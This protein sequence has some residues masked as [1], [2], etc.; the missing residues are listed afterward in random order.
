MVWLKS[1]GQHNAAKIC[2][3]LTKKLR[4]FPDFL[5]ASRFSYAFAYTWPSDILTTSKFKTRILKWMQNVREVVYIPRLGHEAL[6][7]DKVLAINLIV[8]LKLQIA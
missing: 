3:N 7:S 4:K 5:E 6:I 8:L 1:W 2:Q